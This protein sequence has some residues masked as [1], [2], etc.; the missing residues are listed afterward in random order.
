MEFILDYTSSDDS[1]SDCVMPSKK[2]RLT[3]AKTYVAPRESIK[4]SNILPSGLPLKDNWCICGNPIFFV[5]S[6]DLAKLVR[7]LIDDPVTYAL[8]ITAEDC[9][10]FRACGSGGESLMAAIVLYFRVH[11]SIN[12]LTGDNEKDFQK[13]F[14]A[15]DSYADYPRHL[16]RTPFG[17]I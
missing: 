10:L 12:G 16:V 7:I 13:L 2:P 15:L 3:R 6:A 4:P 14:N 17:L 5:E 1:G 9:K 8:M 11:M